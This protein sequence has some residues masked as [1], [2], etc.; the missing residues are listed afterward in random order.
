VEGVGKEYRREVPGGERYKLNIY[1]EEIQS[2][3]G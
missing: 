3:K 2:L 1:T